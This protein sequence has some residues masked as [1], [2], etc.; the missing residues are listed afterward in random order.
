[1]QDDHLIADI[2]VKALVCNND[3]VLLVEEPDGQFALPGGRMNVGEL[4]Q[5]ALCREVL[6]EIGLEIEVG[7]L[8]D[9]FVFTSKSGMHHFIVIFSA[10][11][12]GDIKNAKLQPKEVKSVDWFPVSEFASTPLRD[13]YR[14]V[15]ERIFADGKIRK[16]NNCCGE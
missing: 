8:V 12:L 13:E 15:F 10:Q 9:C 7:G 11:L 3:S 6:E 1:M 2:P 16:F 14:S 5:A 4:P